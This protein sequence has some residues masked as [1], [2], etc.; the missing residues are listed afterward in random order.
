MA[1][2]THT[3]TQERPCQLCARPAQVVSAAL[4]L[5]A[6]CLRAGSP[7]A[8]ERADSV[9]AA[10]RT[11]FDLP[12]APPRAQPG[13]RC[14]LCANECAIAEGERGYCGLRTARR[15]RLVH[16]AGLHARI[17]YALLAFAPAFLMADLP[18]TPSRQAREAEAAAR[19]QGLTN[20]RPG[21]RHLLDWTP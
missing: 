10:S 16:L 12:P 8:R 2:A 17:P 5:C 21:N 18:C 6:D 7:A 4:G 11:E 3:R 9:H 20:V 1:P 13:A 19:S 15:G 14:L